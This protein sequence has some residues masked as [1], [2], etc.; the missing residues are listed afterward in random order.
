MCEQKI[1]SSVNLINDDGS[2]LIYIGSQKGI[3]IGDV[4]NVYRDGKQ[5]GRIE[6][7][8]VEKLY[9]RTKILS[10]APDEKIK[11]MDVVEFAERAPDEVKSA[12]PA[13]SQTSE[14]KETDT[15]TESKP[16]ESDNN[17]N[18]V[19]DDEEENA[20]V[21]DYCDIS[22]GEID[23]EK[24][25]GLSFKNKAQVTALCINKGNDT[26]RITSVILLYKMF[27]LSEIYS[28]D[29]ASYFTTPEENEKLH[30]N[31]RYVREPVIKDA[32]AASQN[33]LN[34][35]RSLISFMYD[36]IGNDKTGD[37]EVKASLKKYKNIFEESFDNIRTEYDGMTYND[38]SRA[39]ANISKL[40]MRYQDKYD[41]FLKHDAIEFKKL[42]K[43][44]PD[45]DKSRSENK[46]ICKS[47]ETGDFVFSSHFS[48]FLDNEA[49]NVSI[50]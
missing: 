10:V 7:I 25:S 27:L 44:L 18:R 31:Y 22:A 20:L 14:E 19:V 29:T 41:A 36:D 43:L 17:E 39:E 26:L 35:L 12:S 42:Q 46:N 30:D 28:S 23:K 38:G 9:S 24:W 6:V 1:L 11:E 49:C 34:K 40:L 8:A 13:P 15:S 48:Y 37:D 5:V 50:D 4:F 47:Y 21:D 2:V 33:M 45:L 3:K 32:W 16:E